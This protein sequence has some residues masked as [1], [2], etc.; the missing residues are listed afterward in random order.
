[1]PPFDNIIIIPLNIIINFLS[2][3]KYEIHVRY[4]GIHVEI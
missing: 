2:G 1:M 3:K 4:L